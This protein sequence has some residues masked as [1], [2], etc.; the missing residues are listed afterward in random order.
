MNSWVLNPPTVKLDKKIKPLT[1]KT[2]NDILSI[3]K[4]TKHKSQELYIQKS[5]RKNKK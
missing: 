3:K 1:I 2:N 4:M 5:K